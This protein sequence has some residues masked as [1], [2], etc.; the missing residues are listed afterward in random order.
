MLKDIEL[1]DREEKN[2]SISQDP[3]LEISRRSLYSCASVASQI[4]ASLIQ[5]LKYVLYGQLLVFIT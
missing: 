5:L 3:N 2:Y 4:L 1:R